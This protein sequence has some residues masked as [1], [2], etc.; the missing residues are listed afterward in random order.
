MVDQLANGL[1]AILAIKPLLAMLAGTTLGV[2]VGAVPGLTATMG[3][4]LLIPFTYNL[5]TLTALGLLA[6]IHN[7]AS[8][9]GAIP[10]ILLRIPGTH[11]A[12]VTCFDGYPMAQKGEAAGALKVAAISSGVG[13]MLS[14]MALLA[15][16]LPL[17]EVTLA[18]GPPEI[19]WVNMFGL[20]SVSLLLQGDPIKGLMGACFGML[21]G[22]VGLDN[23]TG[24]ER[25][26]FGVMELT[27]G[28]PLLVVMV[29]LFSLPP[30][31][32]M[33][34]SAGMSAAG[35]DALGRSYMGR[36]WRS[37]EMLLTWL[38]S[39]LIGIFIGIL[40]GAS[41]IGSFIAYGEARRAS[42]NPETFGTGNPIGVAAAES[43]NNADNAASMVP[44]LT[45]GIPGGGAAALM[46]A[47]LLVHGL[48]PGPRLF[49]NSPDIFYGYTLQMFLTSAML[50]FV[51]G[52]VA[53]RF[54]AGV[55]R[56]PMPLLMPLVICMTA[57]AAY[58]VE[59]NTYFV[60]VMF[61]FG[62]IGLLLERLRFPIA[63]I[64]IGLV[65]GAPAELNLRL[66]LLIAQGDPSILWTRPISQGVIVLTV[67]VAL[68]PVWRHYR[69]KA[70][71]PKE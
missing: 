1:V 11:G 45:L 24:H 59:N 31:W 67:M 5:D 16:A 64:I 33:V 34:E 41:G 58:A 20:A 38:K 43:V 21:I 14:A 26:A 47:A 51:G 4:A 35:A 28:I 44:A 50:L 40:P 42:K 23:V 10:A 32:A 15:F 46:L 52:A 61:V 2:F 68:F 49:E 60:G 55:L 56:L 9:G 6:G 36:I 65:L 13:G 27:S 70:H 57:V 25:F 22:V 29:G 8:Y 48:Q 63:P 18:F 30:T 71:A 69:A 17:A 62:V 37:S 39:S 12:I 66:S 7:G 3:I 19:F 53:S 54:F